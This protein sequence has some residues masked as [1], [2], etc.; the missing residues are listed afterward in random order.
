MHGLLIYKVDRMLDPD[1][2]TG[3]GCGLNAIQCNFS[4]SPCSLAFSQIF[5]L[6]MSRR[7]T[8]HVSLY[9]KRLNMAGALEVG[10]SG[11]DIRPTV[12]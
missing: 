1:A 11:L 7:W 9:R 3:E 5:L 4:A 8:Q 6:G 2:N 10:S 12:T